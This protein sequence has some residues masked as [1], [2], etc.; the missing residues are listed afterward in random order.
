MKSLIKEYG[1]EYDPKQFTQSILFSQELMLL[2]H[3]AYLVNK[4]S[5]ELANIFYFFPQ[6]LS[7]DKSEPFE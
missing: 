3:T 7:F 5:S 1:K 4:W 2:I 6:N